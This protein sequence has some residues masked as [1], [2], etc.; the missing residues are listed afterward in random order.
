MRI[1]LLVLLMSGLPM[2][3][4]EAAQRPQKSWVQGWPDTDF[5]KTNIKFGEIISG[6]VPK[7]GIPAIDNPIFEPVSAVTN[8]G[9]HEPVISLQIAGE[10]RAYPLRILMYHEIVNDQIADVPF[11]VTYCPLCN[12]SIVFERTVNGAVL[13]FGTT[14]KLRKSDMVM[15]DRQ[16]ESWWQQFT[17]LGLIG[18]FTD[19]LLDRIPSRIESIEQFAK[20]HPGGKVLIPNNPQARPYGNNP[21]VGY[22]SAKTPFLYG[23][24]N[25]ALPALSRVVAVEDDA[26]PLEL[27][28]QEKQIVHGDLR[29]TWSAGQNSAVDSRQISTGKDVGNVV[30][31]RIATD[32][33]ASDVI[34]HLPFAFA[35]DAFQ[36]DGTL[37]LKLGE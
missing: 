9:A 1:F 21:Y 29:L 30:A 7:D 32:G 3:Q 25:G 20:R 31:Q 27:L 2:A 5:S 22:D 36:P 10:A 17:G 16:S 35:F 15:Y 4:A 26:W 34:Y 18:D 13:D 19:T 14:G 12:T 11:S 33:S 28:K 24:Y 8:L 37:H 23:K 6:G